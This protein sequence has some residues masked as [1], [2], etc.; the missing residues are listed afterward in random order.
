MFLISETCAVIS[1]YIIVIV[2]WT[3][4]LKLLYLDTCLAQKA[5]EDFSLQQKD[6]YTGKYFINIFTDIKII[7][8]QYQTNSQMMKK[9]ESGCRTNQKDGGKLLGEEV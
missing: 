5:T 1:Y 4:I 3:L 7:R 2:L 9:K 8:L 6:K